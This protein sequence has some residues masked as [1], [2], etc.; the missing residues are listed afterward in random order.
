[1]KAFQ[2]V[3]FQKQGELHRKYLCPSPGLD[4]SW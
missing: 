2:F 1:M 4:R 3:E